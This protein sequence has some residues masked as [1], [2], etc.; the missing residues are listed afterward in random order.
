MVKEDLF[1][2]SSELKANVSELIK[3]FEAKTGIS[4]TSINV[5][6][7]R[8]KDIEADISFYFKPQGDIS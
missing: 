1:K 4:I 2:L 3:D 5:M 6:H 7:K 8:E